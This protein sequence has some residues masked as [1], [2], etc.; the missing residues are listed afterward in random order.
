MI[1]YLLGFFW[2]L[3]YVFIVIGGFKYRSEK[4]FFMPLLSGA[5]NFG[6]EVHA[7][8]SSGG[9]WVHIIWLALDFIILIQNLYFLST[10][11][12][13]LLYSAC[14]I[15]SVAV[16]YAA[17]NLTT[18]DG[19]LISS[20]VIDIIMAVEY[21]IVI[22]KL[23]PRMMILI[24]CLRLLGDL[25]AWIANLSF[26]IFVRITGVL[27]FFINLFYICYALEILS[28]KKNTHQ[29]KALHTYHKKR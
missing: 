29:K 6:W 7:L 8:R 1:E 12:K 14:V 23:S 4:K 25:F 22:K 27:I 24:G 18:I 5:L 11:K 19:M 13:R 3:T 2:A 21:V 26:S 15:T 28:A 16:N 10:N 9:Y 17:F 20:F